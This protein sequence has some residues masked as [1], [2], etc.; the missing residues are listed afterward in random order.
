MAIAEFSI[1][2]IGKGAS[3][4]E[5]VARAV[6]IVDRSGLTYRLNPMGTVVEGPFDEVL[7]LIAKCHKAVAADCERVSTVIKIDDR[8]G[9]TGALDSKVA[10]VAKRLGRP[11]RT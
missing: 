2:P 5:Y 10:A 3:V 6:D 7:A 11:L 9:A 1:T 4:G 8:R